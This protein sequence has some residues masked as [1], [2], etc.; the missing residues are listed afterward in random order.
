MQNKTNQQIEL[1]QTK[2]PHV[3]NVK[4]N[5]AHQSR[6]IGRIDTSGEGT[7]VT[8]R[9]EKHLFRKS[10]SL[11]LSYSLLSDEN[12]KFKWI[13]ISLNGQNFI[14]TRN[15]FL[16]N[17]KAYQFSNKGF[18]LQIFVTLDELN[19]K[20]AEQFENSIGHQEDFFNE[21]A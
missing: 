4:L 15:Y 16:K 5:L 18:E 20:T 14:S 11:G 21:V 12:I 2:H 1:L 7:F 19:L 10:N 13:V 3:F 9:T 8:Q 6:F 17:G